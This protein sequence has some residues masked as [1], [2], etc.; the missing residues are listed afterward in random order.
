VCLD[1]F[2]GLPPCGP[3]AVAGGWGTD[4]VGEV[5]GR[6]AFESADAL[7]GDGVEHV[8]EPVAF[9]AQRVDFDL[10]DLVELSANLER[11]FVELRSAAPVA[12]ETVSDLLAFPSRGEASEPAAGLAEL[13]FE[14]CDP[15]AAGS[16]RATPTCSSTGSSAS[17]TPGPTPRTSGR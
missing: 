6:V 14:P 3:V 8:S 1:G 5:G 12:I 17:P 9:G 2:G 10:R 13:A 11:L 16:R 4:Q 7:S 15:S